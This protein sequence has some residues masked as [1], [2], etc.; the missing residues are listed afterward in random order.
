MRSRR[1]A[2]P[3]PPPSQQ[4]RRTCGQPRQ[5]LLQALPGSQRPHADPAAPR[6][7]GSVGRV[8]A[9]TAAAAALR[10]PLHPAPLLPHPPLLPLLE[11]LLLQSAQPLQQGHEALS[12]HPPSAGQVAARAPPSQHLL[13]QGRGGRKMGGLRCMPRC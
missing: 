13:Q 4:Q 9:P 5:G 2:S 6:Y 8:A 1:A 12:V 7:P 3:L 10:L 11:G